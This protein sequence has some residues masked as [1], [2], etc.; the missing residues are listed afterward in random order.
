MLQ[1]CLLSSGG[2]CDSADKCNGCKLSMQLSILGR[3]G[4]LLCDIT[5]QAAWMEAP[6]Y[7]SAY[8]AFL[9]GELSGDTDLNFGGVS[10]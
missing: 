7:F 2:S 3:D 1:P 9:S 10:R 8:F 5:D 6:E 4:L